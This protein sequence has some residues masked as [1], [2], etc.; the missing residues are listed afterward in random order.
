MGAQAW[1]R[2][3]RRA[4]LGRAFKDVQGASLRR[5]YHLTLIQTDIGYHPKRTESGEEGTAGDILTADF[6]GL[7]CTLILWPIAGT[8]TQRISPNSTLQV[9]AS[10]HTAALVTYSSGTWTT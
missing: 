9:K 2:V 8:N 7:G 5:S 1:P 6:V 3:T 10:G 4:S